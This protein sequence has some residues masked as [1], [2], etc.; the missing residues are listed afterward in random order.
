MQSVQS[1]RANPVWP[2]RSG[3]DAMTITLISILA[4]LVLNVALIGSVVVLR[5]RVTHRNQARASVMSRWSPR[6]HQ[7]LAGET[8][9]NTLLPLVR[10]SDRTY[11]VELATQ[12][13]QRVSGIELDR[14]RSL[15]RPFLGSVDRSLSSHCAETRA[16]AVQV[17]GILG[18]ERCADRLV[19]ALDD[20]SPLVAMV[21]ATALSEMG[22][23]E[24]SAEVVSH[25]ERFE[26]WSPTFLASMLASGGTAMGEQLRSCLE[27]ETEPAMTRSVAADALRLMRDAGSADAAVAVLKTTGDREVA[28]A[29]LRLLEALG[30]AAHVDVVRGFTVGEDSVLR[31]YAITALGALATGDGDIDLLDI[32]IDDPSPW[33]ALHAARAL[34]VAG[35]Q[36]VLRRVAAS[37]RPGAGAAREVLIGEPA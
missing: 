22:N 11:L 30:T 27:C 7:L 8:S 13:G 17:I 12:Y 5:L 26:L 36:N 23:S 33:V 35:R 32:A 24:L 10:R 29:C 31:A 9:A 14:L 16:R 2:H 34:R 37:R 18:G 28:A 20:K 21:A 4:M 6:I 3:L 25:L 19:A 15:G 1:K